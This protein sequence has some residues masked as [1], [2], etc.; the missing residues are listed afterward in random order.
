MINI[1]EQFQI[2]AYVR[3]QNVVIPDFAR[4]DKMGSTSPLDKTKFDR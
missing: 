1:Q 3:Y 2:K 4:I